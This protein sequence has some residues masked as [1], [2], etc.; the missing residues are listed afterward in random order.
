M[1]NDGVMVD[2]SFHYHL[3]EVALMS[4]Y[5]YTAKNLV[6]QALTYLTL[7]FTHGLLCG[8]GEELK[9]AFY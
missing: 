7:S 3:M 6:N 4:V 8:I 2:N 5:L 9:G 1:G